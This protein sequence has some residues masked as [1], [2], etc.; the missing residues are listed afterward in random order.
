MKV[1]VRIRPFSELEKGRK[2][3]SVVDTPDDWH[4]KLAFRATNKMYWYNKALDEACKQDI[5]FEECGVHDLIQSALDGYAATI[6]AY[7][8]T[9]SGKTYTM[10]GI[11]DKIGKEG[12]V[13]DQNDGLIPWSVWYMWEQM[14][15]W[16]Q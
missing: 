11:E 3:Q 1:V 5:V 4:I 2:D 13:S 6:F 15:K 8:Q 16:N 14:T 9:G 7:G 12:W 10:S